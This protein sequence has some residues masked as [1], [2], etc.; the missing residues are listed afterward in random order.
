[1][2]CIVWIKIYKTSFIN[3]R[4]RSAW[5]GEVYG[6][7]GE[8]FH[9]K[10][11]KSVVKSVMLYA[12]MGSKEACMVYWVKLKWDFEEDRESKSNGESDV[13]CEVDG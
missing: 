10:W 8:L 6:E 9:G 1:M 3:Y 5:V 7:C 4:A 12:C 11:I 2:H 13:W